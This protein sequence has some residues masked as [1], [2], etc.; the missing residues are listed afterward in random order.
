MIFYRDWIDRN[1][2]GRG[3]DRPLGSWWDKAQE[4]SSSLEESK[5]RQSETSLIIGRA[6]HGQRKGAIQ[7]DPAAGGT[8]PYRHE[9]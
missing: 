5:S 3:W 9:G 4:D 7:A 8:Q 2:Q 6:Q 1:G